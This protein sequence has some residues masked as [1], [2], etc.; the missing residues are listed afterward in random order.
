MAADSIKTSSQVRSRMLRRMVM[1]W[2]VWGIAVVAVVMLFQRQVRQVDAVGL[3]QVDE[4]VIS[5]EE[6]GTVQEVPLALL[7]EVTAGQV[8][9]IM[10]DGTIEAELQA[11]EAA[12]NRLRAELNGIR[13]APPP[14]NREA[15]N[16][17]RLLVDRLLVDKR[18]VRALQI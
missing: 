7:E 9:A 18:A 16:R 10:D 8:V 4:A 6:N 3:V 11:A 15:A 12:L 13:S 1:P 17:Q 5:P 2:V 14:S